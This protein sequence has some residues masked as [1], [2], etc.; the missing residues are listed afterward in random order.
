MD[1]RGY[2]LYPS[3]AAP[4]PPDEIARLVGPITSVD[5]RDVSTLGGAFELLP[6]CHA[7]RTQGQPLDSTNYTAVSGGRPR[8]MY[9][10]LPMRPGHSYFIKQVSRTDVSAISPITV[11]TFAEEFDHGG[12]SQRV[13]HPAKPGTPADCE[14]GGDGQ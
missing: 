7:V 14:Q 8:A 10:V 9:F 3:S 4:P 6:G 13:F 11:T 5:G 12:A 1:T 2:P